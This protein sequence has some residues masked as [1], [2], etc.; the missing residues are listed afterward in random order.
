MAKGK[1]QFGIGL[2]IGI[3]FAAL[4][5]MYFAPRYTT[6][7][8]DGMLYKHDRWSGNS[9]RFVDS[10]WQK[11]SQSEKNWEEIDSQL[12]EALKV[13]ATVKAR[14]KVLARLREKYPALRSVSDEDILERIKFVYSKEL[15]V[16]H[17]LQTYVNIEDAEKKK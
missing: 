1:H 8:T 12:R 11:V 7:E 6:V 15:M 2:V 4:F 10:G 3:I 9:W 5:F 13:P 16:G 17:Y 14:K